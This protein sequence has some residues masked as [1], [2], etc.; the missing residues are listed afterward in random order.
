MYLFLYA[1]FSQFCSFVKWTFLLRYVTFYNIPF[2]YVHLCSVTS[3]FSR[4]WYIE[5]FIFQCCWLKLAKGWENF[6]SEISTKIKVSE[7]HSIVIS[8]FENL[9]T[10]SQIRYS[11]AFFS[12]P[13][14]TELLKKGKNRASSGAESSFRAATYIHRC[15]TQPYNLANSSI[16][17]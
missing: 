13:S 11:Q 8:D 2:S 1:S 15:T 16:V 12:K 10:S 7:I 5:D 4:A 9:V 3:S 17:L 14:R 6:W